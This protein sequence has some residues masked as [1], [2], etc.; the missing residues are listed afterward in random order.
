MFYGGI[1]AYDE[2]LTHSDALLSSA[3]WR[4]LL[5][6]IGNVSD[7][8]AMVEVIRSELAHLE[9]IQGEDMELGRFQF[10]STKKAMSE[11]FESV[12]YQKQ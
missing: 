7:C 2:A 12:D 10:A 3:I 9:N 1:L 6:S 11:S 4:N 5:Q 8:A